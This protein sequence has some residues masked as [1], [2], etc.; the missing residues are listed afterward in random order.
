MF[1]VVPFGAN[2]EVG[3]TDV[4]V[5][6]LITGSYYLYFLTFRTALIPFACTANKGVSVVIAEPS[7]Q[8][9]PLDSTY[10]LMR[11]VGIASIVLFGIGLPALFVAILWQHRRAMFVDQ[12]LRMRNEGETAMTNPHIVVRRRYRKLYEDYTPGRRYWK[13]VLIARKMLLASV[14]ILLAAQPALQ[15]RLLTRRDVSF[16][17]ESPQGPPRRSRQQPVQTSPGCQ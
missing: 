9:S 7:I 12:L 2:T 8:C 5:G 16:K 17:S 3:I 10:V 15:V 4:C 11:R 6:I 1:H 14:G 13:L